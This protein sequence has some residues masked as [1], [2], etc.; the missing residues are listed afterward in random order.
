M[1]IAVSSERQD[2]DAQVD[3]LFG[4]CPCFLLVDTETMEWTA[5]P[6]AAQGASGGAGIAAAQLVVR[7][8]ATAVLTGNVGPNAMQVLAAAR[9]PVYAAGDRTVKDAI[10]AFRHGTLEPLGGPT[11][12]NDFGKGDAATGGQ[13]LGRG[14]RGGGR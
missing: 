10:D 9:I 1:L 2:L 6:N 8:G 5:V 11:V 7:Q 12:A 14:R 3:R 13:S 4:R